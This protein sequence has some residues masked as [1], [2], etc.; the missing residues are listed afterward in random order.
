MEKSKIDKIIKEFRTK[1][2]KKGILDWEN[3]ARE[4]KGEKL[5]IIQNS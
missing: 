3:L 1:W 5:K 4:L 2:E